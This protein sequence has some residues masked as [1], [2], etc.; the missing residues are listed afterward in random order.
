M[1]FSELCVICV[2]TFRVITCTAIVFSSYIAMRGHVAT[3][4]VA[5]YC[6]STSS[7][8]LATIVEAYCC[9]SIKNKSESLAGGHSGLSS[10]LL[11]C[12]P[13]AS[14]VSPIHPFSSPPPSTT[15]GTIVGPKYYPSPSP[16]VHV[17][18]LGALTFLLLGD[19]FSSLLLQKIY[20][21]TRGDSNIRHQGLSLEA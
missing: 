16:T 13:E 8:S 12:P 4:L 18:C 19:G 14:F 17:F 5:E 11:L 21:L 2:Q 1:Q 10:S 9:D 6:L 7:V 20:M 15:S 3:L